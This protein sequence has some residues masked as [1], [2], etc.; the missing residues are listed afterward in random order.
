MHKENDT[1]VLSP[2]KRSPS[3]KISIAVSLHIYMNAMVANKQNTFLL[4]EKSRKCN[5]T[6]PEFVEGGMDLYS[7]Y[8]H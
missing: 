6:N 1:F 4:T 2:E 8:T 5:G 3:C 7:T